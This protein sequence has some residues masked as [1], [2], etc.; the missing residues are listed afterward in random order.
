MDSLIP[1]VA[2]EAVALQG[3][4]S[5]LPEQSQTQGPVRWTR[6]VFTPSSSAYP[7]PGGG[8][9]RYYLPMKSSGLR[10]ADG[11]VK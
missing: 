7:G 10:K 3:F 11:Q 1:P 2:V 9:G 5:F 4:S 6:G 8:A